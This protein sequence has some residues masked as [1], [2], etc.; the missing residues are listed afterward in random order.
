MALN[1]VN[2]AYRISVSWKSSFDDPEDILDIKD[3]R[4]STIPNKPSSLYDHGFVDS[5]GKRVMYIVLDYAQLTHGV[6]CSTLRD[7]AAIAKTAIAEMRTAK[8]DEHVYLTAL[9]VS[10]GNNLTTA[11]CK[12]FMNE[13][14]KHVFVA[15]PDKDTRAVL[16]PMTTW[17]DAQMLESL[18]T[19]ESAPCAPLPMLK[20][21]LAGK[22][23]MTPETYL[24]IAKDAG[25]K[26][27]AP[28][29]VFYHS[30]AYVSIG[31]AVLHSPLADRIV[32]SDD[33]V[34]V[35]AFASIYP[36]FSSTTLSTVPPVRA[37]SHD[38]TAL[39]TYRSTE[40]CAVFNYV[41]VFCPRGN[42]YNDRL[43]AEFHEFAERMSQKLQPRDELVFLMWGKAIDDFSDLDIIVI[44]PESCQGIS[45]PHKKMF[46]PQED[47]TAPAFVL[48][49]NIT[50]IPEL[51]SKN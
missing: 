11:L 19:I 30:G 51:A 46:T 7:I 21:V 9:P 49:K 18:M 23:E 24:N 13:V 4:P 22:S 35:R 17:H 29:M 14:C 6:P 2:L 32:A 41:D 16:L 34:K 40:G 33:A 39:A 45:E 48:T 1:S 47:A 3:H 25:Q 37:S 20:E 8:F 42:A 27:I 31:D 50:Q 44:H 43:R 10:R 12:V 38:G 36:V 26:D 5:N 15:S 28:R